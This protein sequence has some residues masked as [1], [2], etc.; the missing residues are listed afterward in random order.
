M[1]E[2]LTMGFGYISVTFNGKEM[3]NFACIEWEEAQTMRVVENR[4]RKNPKADW[5]IH[6]H[7]PLDDRHYQRQGK[8]L[9]VLYEKGQGFA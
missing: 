1:N 8:N 3:F 9:W 6:F 5:R 7:G 4:A 2:K